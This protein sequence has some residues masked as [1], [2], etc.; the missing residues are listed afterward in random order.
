M[1]VIAHSLSFCVTKMN[2]MV[3]YK[4]KQCFFCFFVVRLPNSW[5]TFQLEIWDA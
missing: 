2:G 3:V 5:A 4:S 1:P